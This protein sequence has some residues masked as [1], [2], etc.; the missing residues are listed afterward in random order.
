MNRQPLQYYMHD[1]SHAFRF[2]LSGDL[3]RDGAGRLDQ[4]W[5]TARPVVGDRRLIVD[6]T[7]VTRVDETGRALLI[8]W[9]QEG[10]RLVANSSVS[11]TLAESILGKPLESH[12]T[13]G[14]TGISDGTWLPFRPSSLMGAVGL[15]LFATA[16][17]PVRTLA[18][19]A[20]VPAPA[21]QMRAHQQHSATE[22]SQLP[23]FIGSQDWNGAC[24]NRGS[25]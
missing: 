17:F 2:E 24:P 23:E 7:F 11:R 12:V 10:A 5:R 20:E 3:D 15:I 1:G 19:S 4:A 9:D 16:L 25:R 13:A 8:R 6:M 22:S 21:E 14:R 18:V